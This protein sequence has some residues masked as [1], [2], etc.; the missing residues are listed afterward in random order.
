MKTL[1]L[2]VLLLTVVACGGTDLAPCTL[3]QDC[4]PDQKCVSNACVVKECWADGDC[5]KYNRCLDNVC[6]EKPECADDSECDGGL[7]CV[8]YK[9][10][11]YTTKDPCLQKAC[12]G[13]CA[14]CGE[15]SACEG[16]TCIEACLVFEHKTNEIKTEVCASRPTCERCVCWNKTPPLDFLPD[17]YGAEPGKCVEYKDPICTEQWDRGRSQCLSGNCGD[18]AGDFRIWLVDQLGACP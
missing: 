14:A 7:V 5:P 8:A 12:T 10:Q 16:G 15:L 9:C 4:D 3:D 11:L 13:D 2:L 1:S 17:P 18:W 6:I